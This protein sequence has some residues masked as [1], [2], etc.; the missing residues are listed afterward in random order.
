[1]GQ[2]AHPYGL[3]LGYIRTWKSKWYA[4]KEYVQF[5]HEDIAIRKYIKK[6]LSFA[7][8]SSIEVERFSGKVRVRI[9]TARPGIIIGRRGQEIDRIKD[10]LSKITPDEI[11]ID[12]KEVKIPQVNAQLVAENVAL[13]LEKRVAFRRAMKK[14]ISAAMMKG[15]GGIKIMC[16]GR[17][18]G[19]EIA[20]TE[21]YKEGKV[22]LSTFRADV[23]YG[24]IEANT[25]YG[26]IGVKCWIYKGEVLVKKEEAE[27]AKEREARFKKR[28]KKEFKPKSESKEPSESGVVAAV[29]TVKSDVVSEPVIEK[30]DLKTDKATEDKGK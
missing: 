14:A 6:T 17:L 24:C 22:P 26:K 12:I 29:A 16:G 8:I 27:E 25:T 15:A 1:M 13:Q 19:T 21:S 4:R 2:K 5:L 23:E 10:S 11:I 3:R 20:R 7:G 18:G 9:F 30:K 28:V